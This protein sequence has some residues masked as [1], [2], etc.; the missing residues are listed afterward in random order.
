MA[1]DSTPP[2]ATFGDGSAER[3]RARP[4]HIRSRTVVMAMVAVALLV[5][6][7][8]ATGVADA[9]GHAIAHAF[10]DLMLDGCGDG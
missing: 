2:E 8:F 10:P 7:F 9:A 1:F 3:D 5:W 6:A 4:P